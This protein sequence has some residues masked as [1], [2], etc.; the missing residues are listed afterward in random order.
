M[1]ES[2]FTKYVLSIGIER[3][4]T[5]EAC[6]TVALHWIGFRDIKVLP[7]CMWEFMLFK[8]DKRQPIRQ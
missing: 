4:I 2:S 5:N 6:I 1:L 3:Y 8:Q 7:H